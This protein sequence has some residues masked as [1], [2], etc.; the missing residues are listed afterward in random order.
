MFLFG[1]KTMSDG[2]QKSAGDKMRKTL[3]FMTGNR[4]IGVLTGFTA[5][6]IIQSSTAFS[7][8][9]VSFVNAGLLTLTQS[10]G[11][12]FGLNIGTTLTGWII[13]IVGFRINLN[14]LALPLIGIGF[15]ISIIKWRYR[16][17]GDFLLGFGFLFIGLQFLTSGMG[18]ETA[19]NL[20][21]FEAIGALRDNRILVVLIGT[22]IGL[23]L[24]IIVNSST[25]SITLIMALAFQ[26]VV[27]YDMAAGMVMGANLGTVLNAVLVSLAGNINAKRTALVH[28]MFNIIGL[29][30]A[31]PLL[32]PMLNFVNMVLPGDPW[33]YALNNEAIPLHLAGLHTMY[34]I[35]NTIIFLPFVNQ[36]AKLICFMLPDKKSEKKEETKHYKFEYLHTGNADSPELNIIR[37]EKEI[38]DMAGIV[39]FMYSRFS[40]TLN[41]LHEEDD[42]AEKNTTELCAEL[43][44]KEEYIDEMRDALSSFLIECNA[45]ESAPRLSKSVSSKV[46]D[47]IFKPAPYT[48]TRTSSLLRVIVALEEMSDECYSISRV[49]EKSVRKNC[50]FKSKEMEALTPYVGQV[51]EFL[52]LVENQL[53]PNPAPNQKA[54]AVKLEKQIDKNRKKLQKLGRKRIEAGKNVRTELIFIDLVRRIERLGDYCFE[55][56]EAL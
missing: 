16:S 21:D 19:R 39:S 10:V 13:S 40:T 34:N 14:D 45:R 41:S 2:L 36:F 8:I 32:L 37:A 23:L 49:L 56:S 4:F 38:S 11:V 26:D 29:V 52:A 22:G 53:S 17:I 30:W 35:I 18:T 12:I 27:N 5:T 1:M 46:I 28:V 51:E 6:A 25:A 15:I 47:T 9:I 31:L 20:L 7:V 42:K 55:I 24:T 44:A 33:A 50:V 43:L 48:E 54:Q 3:N